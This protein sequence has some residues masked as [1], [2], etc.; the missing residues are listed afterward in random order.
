MFEGKPY[1][2]NN[3][4]HIMF[5][6]E[7]LPGREDCKHFLNG[8]CMLNGT[9]CNVTRKCIKEKTPPKFTKVRKGVVYSNIKE[10]TDG[11]YQNGYILLYEVHN[12]TNNSTNTYYISSQEYQTVPAKQLKP[13]ATISNKLAKANINEEFNI[14]QY[15][16]KVISIKKYYLN[17]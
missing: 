9:K 17:K 15:K 6:K 2:Y 8:K 3:S 4:Y 13:E 5:L 7:E 11:V 10:Y 12:Y 1:K 14:N 16:Y